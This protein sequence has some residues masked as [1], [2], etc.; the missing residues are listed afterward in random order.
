MEEIFGYKISY[1][2]REN[3]D[4]CW[5]D[6]GVT[7]DFVRRLKDY[8]KVNHFP[9]MACL[10]RK[11]HLGRN[12]ARMQKAFKKDYEFFPKTWVLPGDWN[13][14][15]AEINKGQGNTYIVKPEGLSQG[16]GIFLTK[17]INEID[18][19]EHNVVQR[20][21]ANPYL[22]DGLKFD[23]RIYCLVYG[24]DPLR[25]YVYKEGLARFSTDKYVKPNI[26]NIKDRYMHLTNYAIN[27]QSKNFVYNCDSENPNIGHKRSLEF[28]WNYIDENGGNSDQLKI[29]IQE[30][31]VKTLCAVQPKLSRCYR[32]CQPNNIN[33]NICFE[34]L[35]FDILLE[36]NLKPW[37]LE[38]NHSPS[39]N[40][41]TPFD[42]KIKTELIKDTVKL[43]YLN[44]YAKLKYIEKEKERLDLMVYARGSRD[45]MGKSQKEELKKRAMQ[46]RDHYELKNCGGFIR[47]YP[48]ER[49]DTKYQ[50]FIDYAE[51]E[52]EHFFGVRKYKYIRKIDPANSVKFVFRPPIF[53]Q[54]GYTPERYLN[55]G[56]MTTKK[57]IRSTTNY[58][59]EKIAY[60]Y[61][62]KIETINKS[63][64]FFITGKKCIPK[65]KSKKTTQS[66]R[67]PQT[68]GTNFRRTAFENY[69]EGKIQS[70]FG[71]LNI[72]TRDSISTKPTPHE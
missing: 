45:S 8:Q 24:C 20:Y 6:S 32:S 63:S 10:S 50:E 4:L 53:N 25:I 42:N 22:I 35:G 57:S 3:W 23:L 41:D 39:F 52:L 19:N 17:D 33:N 34:L 7:P 47:I 46:I 67:R 12:L 44:P 48:D 36:D 30:Y 18:L 2:Q 61:G 71:G 68:T 69:N 11:N 15:E 28:I 51:A 9:N 27:K 1:N 65:Y 66:I 29:T 60:I 40:I 5:L 16:K 21:I 43:I 31:I 58:R 38:V 54:P 72:K 14:L 64:R 70:I 26:S 56:N 59:L 49:M 55:N 62:A 37:L 13:E